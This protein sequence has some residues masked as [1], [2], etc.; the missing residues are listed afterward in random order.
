VYGYGIWY[1]KIIENQLQYVFTVNPEDVNNCKLLLDAVE[2]GYL[3]IVD[4]LLKYGTDVNKL[5]KSTYGIGCMLLHVASKNKQEEVAKLLISYEAD[6]NGQDE[7]RKTPIFYSIKNAD[8]KITKLLLTNKANVNARTKKGTTTL[9]AAVQKGYVKVIEILLEYNADVNRTNKKGL[10]PLHIAVQ[11]GYVKVIE[12]LLEYNADVNRTNKKGLTPLHIAVQKGYLEVVMFLLKLG[13][14]VHS[15]DELGRTAFH[16]AAQ[17]VHLEIV[18]VL[19]EFGAGIDSNGKFG[20]T[21]L[22]NA[23]QKGNL[24]VVKVL[25]KFGASTDSTDEHGS[26]PLHMA[27]DKGHLEVVEVLLKFGADIDSTDE[28]GRTALHIAAKEGHENV[29][30]ALL[31]YGAD[32]N[33]MSINNRTPLDCAMARIRSYYIE[34]DNSYSDYYDHGRD[35]HAYE[36]I[37]AIYERHVVKMKTANLYVSEKN[38]QSISTNDEITDYQNECE[39]E[40]AC[41]KS[42]EI[43]NPNVTF[44]DILTKGVIQLATYAMNENIKP[45]LR[46]DDYK[47]KFPIYASMIN[48]N[49]RK[50]ERRNELLEQGNDIFHVLF[51]NFPRLPHDCTEKIFSYLSDDDIRTL[52]DCSKPITVSSPNN[53][54]VYFK[55][56]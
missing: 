37:V 16:F 43:S 40:I 4:K 25:L 7:T 56:S 23:A 49:F 1:G 19:L 42:E 36:R 11:K 22:H 6:V 52:I 18:K 47:I 14:N 28:H 55:S 48:S 51:N 17:D 41:M 30:T 10:T 24:K 45:I 31:E 50:G 38:L 3:K 35:I 13:A 46:S 33:I 32:I 26:T 12:I 53:F 39:I 5:Y 20:R 15:K 8:L 9:H 34:R 44:Y 29:F 27:A 21:A 2:K 54:V